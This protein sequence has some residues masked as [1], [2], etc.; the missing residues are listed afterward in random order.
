MKKSGKNEKEEDTMTIKEPGSMDELIYF[1]NRSVGDGNVMCWVY[2]GPCPQCGE[3]MMG[4]PKDEKTGKPKIRA[5]EYVCPECGNYV[6]YEERNAIIESA[7]I[8]Q[9]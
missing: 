4:K 8:Y 3:G 7:E 6:S 9:G 1:T 5:K 2:K